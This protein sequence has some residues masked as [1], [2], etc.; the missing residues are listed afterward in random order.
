VTLGMESVRRGHQSVGEQQREAGQLIARYTTQCG[1]GKM[2]VV[3]SL[4]QG[5]QD[6]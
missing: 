5:G 1:W 4:S 2:I 3:L 6:S